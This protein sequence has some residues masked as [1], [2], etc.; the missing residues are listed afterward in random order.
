[1]LYRVVCASKFSSRRS[2]SVRILLSVL[3]KLQL[4]KLFFLFPAI[5]HPVINCTLRKRLVSKDKLD[6]SYYSY[7][8]HSQ[9][10]VGY[11]LFQTMMGA[12]H[13]RPT[14]GIRLLDIGCGTARTL[15]YLPS[16]V[17]HGFDLSR[18][19]INEAK[20]RYA[21][22]GVFSCALVEEATL[23]E[24]PPFDLVLAV[25]VLHHLDDESALQLMRLAKT[26]LKE[27]GRVVTI[28]PCFQHA[29]KSIAR[30][31]VSQNRG[32]NARSGEKYRELASNTFDQ[33]EGVVKHRAW[34]PCAHWIMGC[35]K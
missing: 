32:Q 4:H 9:H 14:A 20:A 12:E 21:D 30:F 15:D 28:G 11:D 18:D 23:K 35:T 6:A 34:I 5:L 17:Y 13:I 16:L 26:A 27:G 29:Q 22:R 10:P 33:F 7:R 31:L 19:Y 3:V 8:R 25:G 24:D 1:M 2:P